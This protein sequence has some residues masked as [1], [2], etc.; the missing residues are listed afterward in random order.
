MLG[1]A[2]SDVFAR[3]RSLIILLLVFAAI[4]LVVALVPPIARLHRVLE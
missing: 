4:S 3:D 2:A 1:D